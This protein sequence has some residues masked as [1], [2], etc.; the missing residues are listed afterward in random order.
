MSHF[1]ISIF[2]PQHL[3]WR[4]GKRFLLLWICVLLCPLIVGA[5]PEPMQPRTSVYRISQNIKIDGN[6]VEP[7]WQSVIPEAI[8]LREQR[9]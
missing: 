2:V 3:P 4:S 8:V 6:L 1:W 7:N 5:E 9:R